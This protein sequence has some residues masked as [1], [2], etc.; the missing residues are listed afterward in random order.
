MIVFIFSKS[1]ASDKCFLSSILQYGIKL[2][3]K[4]FVCCLFQNRMKQIMTFCF[5]AVKHKL[6][7]KVGYSDLYG[8]DFMVDEDM[9]VCLSE[10]Q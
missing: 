1:Y 7:C 5:N 8:L 9:K 6:Q 4:S 10:T 3:T 2:F